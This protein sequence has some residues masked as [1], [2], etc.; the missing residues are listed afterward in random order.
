[1]KFLIRGIDRHTGQ[2]VN[3]ILVE[4]DSEREAL[5]EATGRGMFT[6]AIDEY[7][8]APPPAVRPPASPVQP[9]APAG[10]QPSPQQKRVFLMVVCGLLLLFSGPCLTAPFGEFKGRQVGPSRWQAYERFR[11][12]EQ[13]SDSEVAALAGDELYISPAEERAAAWNFFWAGMVVFVVPALLIAVHLYRTR[14]ESRRA[15]SSIAAD[16][17]PMR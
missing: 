15:E 17:R 4:A 10:Q 6:E 7:V 5:E 13:L 9:V 11:Q 3:P 16:C 1:M 12:G 2:P 8:S 14:E